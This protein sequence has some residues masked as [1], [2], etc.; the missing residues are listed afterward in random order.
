MLTEQNKGKRVV[1]RKKVR[2]MLTVTSGGKKR[3]QKRTMDISVEWNAAEDGK[4]YKT[5][6]Y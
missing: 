3:K 4:K 2:A 6:D 5:N 1:Q